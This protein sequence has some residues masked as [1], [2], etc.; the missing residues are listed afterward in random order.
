M[1]SLNANAD[2]EPVP[3]ARLVPADQ[4]SWRPTLGLSTGITTL[5]GNLDGSFDQSDVAGTGVTPGLQLA[6]P[7]SRY[8]AVEAWGELGRYKS[9]RSDCTGFSRCESSTL[10][11]GL[12]GTYHVLE[13]IP[14][15]PWLS[16]G[17]GFRSLQWK[18]QTAGNSLERTQTYYGIEAL[19][20][21]LGADYYPTPVLGFGLFSAFTLGQYFARNPGR[22]E[23]SDANGYL[24]FGARVVLRPFNR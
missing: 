18:A 4:R 1:I 8:F 5:F 21:A 19:R 2:D 10:A 6:L 23:G 20:L 16:A 22:L 17:F 13:G 7:V 24:S 9:T 3:K 11:A 12:S 15:D 14:L